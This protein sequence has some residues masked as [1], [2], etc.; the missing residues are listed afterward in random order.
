[1]NFIFLSTSFWNLT[2][3]IGNES[4][5]LLWMLASCREGT[6][7][8]PQ[9]VCQ[10]LS[11][12]ALPSRGCKKPENWGNLNFRTCL[13]PWPSP[14]KA[15]VKV[16]WLDPCPRGPCRQD[17]GP[18]PLQKPRYLL[19][20]SIT[21]SDHLHLNLGDPISG[22]ILTALFLSLF[23]TPSL[24]IILKRP[25]S[26]Q[27]LPIKQY[28]C[29][30]KN[31]GSGSGKA[32]SQ[33]QIKK[34]RGLKHSPWLHA[35]IHVS[36]PTFPEACCLPCYVGLQ[37]GCPEPWTTLLSEELCEGRMLPVLSLPH[38]GCFFPVFAHY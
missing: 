8:F 12:L 26:H 17:K 37:G 35:A 4:F 24:Y 29:R 36:L 38:F 15:L 6:L 33:L 16:E 19:P 7:Q 28:S 3:V 2:V 9:V 21:L 27:P 32:G 5:F 31:I 10:T 30:A 34:H 18:E 14:W 25:E 20:L 13:W 23:F 22:V 1:M 11:A